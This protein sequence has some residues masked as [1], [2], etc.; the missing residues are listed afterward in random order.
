MM[1][2]LRHDDEAILS[3]SPECFFRLEDMRLTTF[4]IKGTVKRGT[5]PWDDAQ[6][7]AALIAD[8]KSRAELL[9]VT[10][11]L[12]NDLGRVCR[13]GTV[14]VKDLA[15][16]ETFSHYHHLISEITGELVPGTTFAAVFAALFPGGSITGAP[17]TKVMEEIARLENRYRGVYTGAIGL[18]GDH[19]F[20][21]FNIPI[22]TL[23]V[24]GDKLTFATGGGI[25][26]DSTAAAEY[27]ECLIK[28]AGILEA[29]CTHITSSV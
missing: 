12:R 28:A 17:K 8:A 25:V 4:P 20:V 5:T 11:M 27:E 1:A 3:A 9:M 13:M 14:R 24:R 10:D 6:N 29:L 22:R 7:T 19:G 16:V 26:V 23:T 15:R 21:E 2:F 18:I